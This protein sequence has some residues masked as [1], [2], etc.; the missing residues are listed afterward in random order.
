[1]SAKFVIVAMTFVS[2]I[3][4]TQVFAQ[5][6]TAGTS[7]APILEE[8]ERMGAQALS[9]AVLLAALGTMSMALIE[10]A[11]AVSRFRLHFNRRLVRKWFGTDDAAYGDMLVL[12]IGDGTSDAVLLDQP[13]EKVLG[14]MQAAANIA[15]DFPTNYPGF[16]QFITRP[17]VRAETSPAL[18]AVVDDQ[19]RWREFATKAAA[20]PAS[21]AAEGEGGK[22]VRDAT[23]ARARLGHLVARRLDAL[24]ADLEYRWARIN[25]LA[26]VVLGASLFLYAMKVSSASKELG[27]IPL[28]AIALVAGLIAPFAKD[29]AGSLAEFG[30]P[31]TT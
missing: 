27:W 16:Y 3:V 31:K 26:G 17:P 21:F 8:L 1:M 22:E 13:S 14:Q 2:G 24:Q 6:E 19:G 9:Y 25:Q 12:A 5:P 20:E 4:A 23:Q 30:K 28:V 29:V 7:H 15:L 18:A 10:F 11:K